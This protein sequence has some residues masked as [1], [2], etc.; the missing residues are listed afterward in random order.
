MPHDFKRFPELTN[1]QMD[2]YYFQSPHIQ[3][4]EDFMARVVKV[5]DGD[6]LRITMDRRDFDFPLRMINIDAPELD[7]RG[8]SASAKWM[9]S[10]ILGKDV[11]VLINSKHRVGKWGRLLGNI[12]F[13]GMDVG[14]ESI[15]NGHS[16]EFGSV[17]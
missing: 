16:I 8:G 14:E 2:F 6:T 11:E 13:Q 9:S 1:R 10:K 5:T 17:V 15:E 12:I 4:T 3:I 7:E